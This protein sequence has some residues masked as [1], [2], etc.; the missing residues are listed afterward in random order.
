M[1]ETKFYHVIAID[2]YT[3]EIR[4]TD[5]IYQKINSL[6]INNYKNDW[7]L[8]LFIYTIIGRIRK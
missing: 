4:Q 8:T 7:S 3:N 6:V 2:N 5:L 1:Q